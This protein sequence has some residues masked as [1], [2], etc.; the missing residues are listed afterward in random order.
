MHV[1][2]P[3]LTTNIIKGYYKAANLVSNVYNFISNA[4]FWMFGIFQMPKIAENWY[5]ENIFDKIKAFDPLGLST[6]EMVS[7]YSSEKYF[8]AST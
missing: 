6:I 4:S 5:F 7:G 2:P 3:G 8:L 1:W